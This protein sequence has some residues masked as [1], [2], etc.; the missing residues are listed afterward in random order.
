[1]PRYEYLC[2]NCSHQFEALQSMRDASLI[3]CPC[4]EG[5]TLQRILFPPTVLD[6][7]PK[8]LGAFADKNHKNIGTYKLQE[9]QEQHRQAKLQAREVFAESLPAG[10]SLAATENTT[11]PWY[12]SGK[13][14]AKTLGSFT[15]QQKKNYIVS[16]DPNRGE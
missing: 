3:I 7:T 4:C 10:A 16:G 9:K 5:N 14:D 13:Y 11:K 1:M 2:G 8:T 15:T 12:L 6:G